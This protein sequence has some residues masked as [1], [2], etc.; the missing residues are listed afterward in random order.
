MRRALFPAFLTVFSAC[1]AVGAGAQTTRPADAQ[2]EERR[3][4]VLPFESLSGA[5]HAAVAGAIGQS[6]ARDLA[7]VRGFGIVTPNTAAED[8]AGAL[9]AGKEAQADFVV[10]GTV[11]VVDDRVRIS[12]ELLDVN[13][14]RSAG[15]FK[16][17]GSN[18][19]L[20]E[21]QDMVAEQVRRRLRRAEI[22]E[23]TE[24]GEA[25]RPEVPASEPLR[26]DRARRFTPDW[27]EPADSVD[28][29][30]VTHRHNYGYPPY[31]A[32]YGFYPYY[33]YYRYS[34]SPHRLLYRGHAADYTYRGLPDR[35]GYYG[36]PHHYGYGPAPLH[37]FDGPVPLRWLR[38][39]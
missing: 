32:P 27:M 16:I 21:L 19:E 29:D 18:R 13:A 3:I 20:F 15:Q 35:R 28:D 33:G 14:N 25:E 2:P 37:S 23:P 39:R 12:G 4:A 11:Q 31:Y 8:A 9:A 30:D 38:R 7:G 24:N 26:V 5:D 17:T 34:Y 1:F 6:V 36:Y 10:W 22:A